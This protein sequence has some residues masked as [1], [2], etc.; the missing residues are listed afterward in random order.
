MS[1]GCEKTLTHYT[2]TRLGIFW[3]SLLQHTAAHCVWVCVC[4]SRP[5][6]LQDQASSGSH[7][8][9]I[10][11]HTATH[12]HQADR[13]SPVFW[14]HCKRRLSPRVHVAVWCTV[15]QCVVV[16]CSRLEDLVHCVAMCCSEDS[17]DGARK[18]LSTNTNKNNTLSLSLCFQT[19]TPTHPHTRQ[20]HKGHIWCGP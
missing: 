9:N 20:N 4:V 14:P 15:L 19:N 8:C 11:Q 5:T 12:K 6:H 17:S 16:Y 1:V 2:P 13:A 18:K 10:L 3:V 7:C